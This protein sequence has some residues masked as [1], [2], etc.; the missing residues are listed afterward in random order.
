M[1]YKEKKI[2]YTSRKKTKKG[3]SNN[4]CKTS[5]YQGTDFIIFSIPSS[6]LKLVFKSGHQDSTR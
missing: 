6:E 2:K 3:F 5:L 1:L 4:S